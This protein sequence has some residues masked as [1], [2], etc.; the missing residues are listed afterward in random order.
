MMGFLLFNP[1]PSHILMVGL[2][3]GSLAKYCYRY[4][5]STRITVLEID[6][7]VIALRDKFMI[8]PD[9]DRFRVVHTDAVPYITHSDQRVDVI[10]LDGFG[11]DGIVPELNSQ[12]FYDA[13]RRILNPEGVLAA[14]LW[15]GDADY[16]LL[17]SRLNV[18]FG[19][20]VWSCNSDDSHNALAF[21]AKGKDDSN[22]HPMLKKRAK[23]LAHHVTLELPQLAARLKSVSFAAPSL[24]R[25]TR[26]D[27]EALTSGGKQ[28]R[29][30]HTV[31][32]FL[33]NGESQKSNKIEWSVAR[34]GVGGTLKLKVSIVDSPRSKKVAR[35]GKSEKR[36]RV[37]ACENQA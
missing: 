37:G 2:G 22:F 25:R 19:Y 10:L 23:Q 28:T 13:C 18:A 3:G 31:V 36:P 1:E 17:M 11:A 30:A 33:S 29:L 35:T 9:D 12:D 21:A 26:S 34:P 7:D 5:P 4:L 6:A 27:S 8:P 15:N 16:P 20:G 24:I 14:N 32:D